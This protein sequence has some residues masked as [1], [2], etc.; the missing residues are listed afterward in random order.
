MSALAQRMPHLMLGF[1]ALVLA[2]WWVLARGGQEPPT[3][4]QPPPAQ[5]DSSAGAGGCD[6]SGCDL[7]SACDCADCACDIGDVCSACDVGSCDCIAVPP[8]AV[9]HTFDAAAERGPLPRRDRPR[10]DR[11]PG[12]GAWASLGLLV[13]LAVMFWW[14]RR[15]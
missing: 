3:H 12:L 11:R 14:R 10:G 13:P 7:G 2:S 6:C 1:A 4:R 15:R 5:Q 8:G 9:S